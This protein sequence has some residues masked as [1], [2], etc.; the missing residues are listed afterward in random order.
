MIICNDWV[1]VLQTIVHYYAA[2]VKLE[3]EI[4]LVLLSILH[5]LDEIHKVETLLTV[6]RF[7]LLL[8]MFM[9]L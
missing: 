3:Y 7:D 4:E 2:N 1:L 5:V 9:F 6:L 8:S